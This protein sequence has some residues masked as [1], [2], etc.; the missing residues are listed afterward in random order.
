MCKRH[1]GVPRF[2]K[3][4]STITKMWIG[5]V[6]LALLSPLGIILPDKLKAGS[7]WGEWGP[8]EIGKMLGFIPQGMN[9]ISEIWHAPLPDYELKGW[10][11]MGPGM[12]SLGYIISAVAGIAVTVA[13][14][15]FLGKIA[16]KN[17]K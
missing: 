11:Q 17:D 5:I 2:L 4:M 13:V 12:Q 7:A 8:D 9:K 14:V 15:I 16:V 6:V 3:N 10:D 1:Y